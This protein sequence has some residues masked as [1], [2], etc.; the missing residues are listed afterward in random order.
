MV[1]EHCEWSGTDFLVIGGSA[2]SYHFKQEINNLTIRNCNATAITTQNG[3]GV[4]AL[5]SP[6][7]TVPCTNN[8]VSWCVGVTANNNVGDRVFRCA[9]QPNRHVYRCTLIAKDFGY[10]AQAIN[11]TGD[12]GEG[13]KVLFRDNVLYGANGVFFNTDYLISTNDAFVDVTDVEADGSLND[14]GTYPG[15]AKTSLLGTNGFEA[16]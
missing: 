7:T 16:E 3:Q 13:E 10:A 12:P 2:Y 14:T 9:E 15:G 5:P 11:S 8:E 4:F 6:S 1:A